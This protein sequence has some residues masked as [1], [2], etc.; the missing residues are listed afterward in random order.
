MTSAIIER[1]RGEQRT[2]LTEPESKQLLEQAGIPTTGGTLVR[3]E[4]EA[5]AAADAVGYPVVL[6]IVSPDVVHK[7]DVG[8][9]V[10]GIPDVAGA[11]AAFRSINDAVRAAMP[12]ARMDGVTVQRQ[13][14]PGVEVIMGMN[15]DPQFGPL[16]MFGLGGVLVELLEDV[17]FRLA[18][19]T[20]RDA[21]QMIREIK[22]LP[23]LTGFRG[24]PPADLEALRGMLL[25]LSAFADGNPDVEQI[26]LNP[27]FAYPN[28]AVAVDARV[29]LSPG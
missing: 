15:R 4:D 9:V 3:S 21:D 28:G 14:Q 18:P 29:V 26:D 19:L 16:L 22:C 1:A 25:A 12:S 11:R 24:S 8:G 20:R 17:A 6:K 2:L 10:V 23:V 13:A 5:A 27:V 7:S